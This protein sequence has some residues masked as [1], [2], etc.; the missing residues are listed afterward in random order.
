MPGKPAFR[1]TV[2]HLG[3]LDVPRGTELGIK[4]RNYAAR[5]PNV[6]FIGIDIT[7]LGRKP[8]LKN[9]RQW[10]TDFLRGLRRLPDNSVFSISSEL[11]LGYHDRKGKYPT[12]RKQFP[13]LVKYTASAISLAFR[14][15]A[16]GR[17]LRI[18]VDEDKLA[19]VRAALGQSPFSPQKI[20]IRQLP[21]PSRISER[22]FWHS[23][24]VLSRWQQGKEFFEIIAEK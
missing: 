23:P 17:T 16:Q 4:T 1:R 2:V 22:D 9:W 10:R 19:N 7:G 13:P 21:R 24:W 18:V 8:P 20:I 6:R 14:K 11:S 15:L 3:N 5:F 12:V